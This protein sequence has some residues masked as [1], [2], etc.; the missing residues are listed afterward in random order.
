MGKKI[1][2]KMLLQLFCLLGFVFDIMRVT[3]GRERKKEKK[4]PQIHYNST[5]IGKLGLGPGWH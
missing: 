5:L 1:C 4:F 2:R 3:T